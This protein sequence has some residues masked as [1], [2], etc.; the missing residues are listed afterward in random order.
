MADIQTAAGKILSRIKDTG[1]KSLDFDDNWS[2]ASLLS[3]HNAVEAHPEKELPPSHKAEDANRLDNELL[4][5]VLSDMVENS[6]L[7][8]H[9]REEPSFLSEKLG[10]IQEFS[11]DVTKFRRNMDATVLIVHKD[12]IDY[13]GN[14]PFLK[15]RDKSDNDWASYDI[16][17]KQRLVNTST[18][19]GTGVLVKNDT[20]VTCGHLLELI[21][22]NVSDYMAVK[23]Y[24][25]SGSSENKYLINIDVHSIKEIKYSEYVVDNSIGSTMN[26]CDLGVLGLEGRFENIEPVRFSK[27]SVVA[28]EEVYCLGMGWGQPMKVS[29]NGMTYFDQTSAIRCKLV[30][31][32]GNSG[33]P[34]FHA[35]THELVGIL[36]GTNVE[37][38]KQEDTRNASPRIWQDLTGY[39]GAI[40]T[41][42]WRGDNS[43]HLAP[44]Y[45]SI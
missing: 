9:K 23:G 41:K 1:V 34:V 3:F 15:R 28:G 22:S 14:T 20:I 10:K 8:L 33:S 16:F 37:I 2:L 24:Y 45:S 32:P 35:T 31:R 18:H 21:K 13:D 36:Y 42:I 4:F 7:P 19:F 44:F 38:Q 25:Y 43:P 11:H 12:A 17:S 26:L 40:F 5:F 30:T 27:R 29:L 6:R 39:D